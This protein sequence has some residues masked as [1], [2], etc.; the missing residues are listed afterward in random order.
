MRVA[1]VA[2]QLAEGVDAGCQF[3][4]GHREVG[5][6]GAGLVVVE[7]VAVGGVLDRAHQAADGDGGVL[8]RL[9]A[10]AEPGLDVRRTDGAH[11]EAAAL[12][13]LEQGGAD[14]GDVVGDAPGVVQPLPGGAG[15][16]VPVAPRPS[17]RARPQRGPAAR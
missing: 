17:R 3:A 5:E 9:H 4:A 13:G 2:D 10:L 7:P 8:E 6:H 14:L 1:L 15:Q 16:A 11:V 12:L